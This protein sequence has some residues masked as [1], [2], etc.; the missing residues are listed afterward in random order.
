MDISLLSG[1]SSWRPV[2]SWSVQTR[3]RTNTWGESTDNT[4]DCRCVSSDHVVSGELCSLRELFVLSAAPSSRLRDID[5]D[6]RQGV[7]LK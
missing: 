3:R 1:C 5:T 4:A 2:N 7:V 6:G